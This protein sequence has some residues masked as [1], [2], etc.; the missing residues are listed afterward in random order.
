[1]GLLE[2]VGLGH[3]LHGQVHVTGGI[4]GQIGVGYGEGGVSRGGVGVQA[5]PVADAH[6]GVGAGLPYFQGLS[7]VVVVGVLFPQGK[8][9]AHPLAQS[10]G[11]GVPQL[12]VLGGRIQEGLE[13]HDLIGSGGHTALGETEGEKVGALGGQTQHIE[14]GHVVIQV[15]ARLC[16]A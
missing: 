9:L 2:V 16:V 14:V 15:G 11:D 3:V 4:L 1:M 5:P 7:I 8:A 12:V 13:E 10:Q 6:H